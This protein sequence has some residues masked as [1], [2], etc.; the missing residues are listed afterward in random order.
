MVRN[1]S[2]HNC[3]SDD[4]YFLSMKKFPIYIILEDIRSAFNVGAFFRT[5]DAAGVE[6]IYLT[7]ITPTPEHPKVAKTALGS[8]QNV[9]WEY[10]RDINHIID[11][12]KEQ[13]TPI[14][15]AEITDNSIEY[16]KFN[17]PKPIAIVFGNEITGICPNTLK[18]SD[19]IVHI[20][21]NGIKESLNVEVSFGIIVYEIIRQYEH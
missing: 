10:N 1:I 15:A 6:K 20:P 2:H 4:Y 18:K 14:V 12:L 8:P 11:K 17:F 16:T 5:A 3:S 21:M 19:A 7:G 9:N 13:N